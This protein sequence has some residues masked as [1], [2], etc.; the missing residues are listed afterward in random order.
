[1]EIYVK[2]GKIYKILPPMI[3]SDKFKK[4]EFILQETNPTDKGTFIEFIRLQCINDVMRFLDGANKGDFVVCKFTISGRKT[5]KGD[6]EMFF[7]NLD[8]IEMTIINK[9]AD[10]INAD[11]KS[12]KES[13]SDLYP[14]INDDDV[15]DD[16]QPVPEDY[17]LPF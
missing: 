13:Y 10:I 6:E 4:Q 9:T 12:K 11:T 15:I 14:G 8:V 3:K 1:M 2:K 16:Q 5:G 17:D 7:T